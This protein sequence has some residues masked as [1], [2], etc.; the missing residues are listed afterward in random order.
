MAKKTIE[1]RLLAKRI[2]NSE[3]NC[4][5]FTGAINRGGYGMMHISKGELGLDKKKVITV[6]RVSYV[7]FNQLEITDID[8]FV[9]AHKC[10]NRNCFNPEHLALVTQHENLT[11]ML[12]KGRGR[13]QHSDKQITDAKNQR[14]MRDYMTWIT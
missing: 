6:H 11:D 12:N 14:D 8:K 9:V 13:N 2:I 5:E 1:E 10:D 7:Y 3:T 4:W